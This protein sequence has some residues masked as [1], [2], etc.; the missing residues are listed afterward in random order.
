MKRLKEAIIVVTQTYPT[1]IPKD[2]QSS[3]HTTADLNVYQEHKPTYTRQLFESSIRGY[4][5]VEA[6]VQHE[7]KVCQLVQFTSTNN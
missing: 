7:I 4:S 3:G 2:I 1:E 6:E 5:F